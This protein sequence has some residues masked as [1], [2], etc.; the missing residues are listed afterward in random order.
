MKKI[1]LSLLAFCLALVSCTGD[2]DQKPHIGTTSN[3]VFST[4]DGYKSMMAKIYA[5]F[6]LKGENK[7]GGDDI[8]T[9]AGYEMKKISVVHCLQIA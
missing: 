4:I 6:I 7:G 9:F 1:Y 2:L 3:E 8:G 5:S